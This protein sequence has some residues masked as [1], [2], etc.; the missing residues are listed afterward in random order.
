MFRDDR[1]DVTV[2]LVEDGTDAVASHVRWRGGAAAGPTPAALG[3]Q[4][5]VVDSCTS[6]I[7]ML[8]EKSF[9]TREHVER[10]ARA[11]VNAAATA[12]AHCIEAGELARGVHNLDLFEELAAAGRS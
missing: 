2:L 11:P 4:A 10:G 5:A 6:T 8:L 7:A 3:G 12:I 1:P 9:V